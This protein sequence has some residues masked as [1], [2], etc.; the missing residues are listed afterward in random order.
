MVMWF[1]T[2]SSLSVRTWTPG[3]VRPLFGIPRGLGYPIFV[4]GKENVW[5]MVSKTMKY[6][7]AMAY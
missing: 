3:L 4:T 5:D 2:L 7:T 1:G 6:V